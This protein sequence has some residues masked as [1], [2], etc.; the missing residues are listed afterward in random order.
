[1]LIEFTVGNFRSFGEKQT[2]SMV[3][4]NSDKTHLSNIFDPALPGLKGVKLVRG[5]ALYGANASGKSN[6]V[7]AVAFARGFVVKSFSKLK[8]GDGT[9]TQPNKLMKKS[10]SAPSSFEFTFVHNRIRYFYS[11]ELTHE[12]V[13]REELIAYPKGLPQKWF[14][15]EFNANSNSYTWEL[16]PTLSRDRRLEENTRENTLFVSTA[17]Q[18]NH[19]KLLPVYQWFFY[20]LRTLDLAGAGLHHGFSADLVN[21]RGDDFADILQHMRMVDIPVDDI[22]VEEVHP[23]TEELEHRRRLFEAVGL[24]IESESVAAPMTTVRFVRGNKLDGS[25]AFFDLLN[26]E[27]E[28]TQRYFSLI[29]PWL[30]VVKNNITVFVDELES[31]LHPHLVEELL[32]ILFHAGNGVTAQVVFTTHNALL[33]GSDI[34]R[35]DQVWFTERTHS[36]ESSLYALTDFSPRKDESLLRGYMNGR[37]GAIP[38]IDRSNST[39]ETSDGVPIS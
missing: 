7:K 38:L 37:Y 6:L 4:S 33:L 31:S 18:F 26:E 32:R 21:R 17:A 14:L 2:L 19:D 11:F 12:R 29:G 24:S 25:P 28:G 13:T 10:E 27:S 23:S 9:G 16:G 5:A 34:L 39:T 1:M 35:R 3:A 30:D 8:P 36:N 22:L 15:R 20:Y